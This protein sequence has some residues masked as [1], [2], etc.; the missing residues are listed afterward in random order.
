MTMENGKKKHLDV[1]GGLIIRDG[2][3]LFCQRCDDDTFGGLWEL[4]GGC[5]EDG[6]SHAEALA[7]EL[8]EELGLKNVVAGS[9]VGTFSDEN[10]D[11]HID[12]YLYQVYRF[13]G[14]PQCIEC[15]D[16]RFVTFAQALLLDLA[17]CDRKMVNFL[18]ETF[19]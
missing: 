16:M 15:K 10:E 18:Q 9:I 6:E 2:R 4:P 13:D 7:R 1:V 3:A 19:S 17:P 5:I 12:V 14:E 11:L 8:N